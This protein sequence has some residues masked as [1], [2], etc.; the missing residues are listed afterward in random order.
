MALEDYLPTE[1]GGTLDPGSAEDQN[2]GD[3]FNFLPDVRVPSQQE[4]Q[5]PN[6]PFA[7][8]PVS[9]RVGRAARGARTEVRRG[10]NRLPE[11]GQDLFV[12]ELEEEQGGWLSLIHI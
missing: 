1:F 6:M 11:E 5:N 3:L 2:T 10:F 4:L 12:E 9:P 8:D 7:T